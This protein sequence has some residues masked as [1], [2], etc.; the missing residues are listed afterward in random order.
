MGD[1]SVL[2]FWANVIWMSLSGV[3]LLGA[4]IWTVFI[5]WPYLKE[6]KQMQIESLKL[7]KESN[8]ALQKMQGEFIPV[9][10][11]LEESIV[12]IR[13][14]VH[15]VKAGEGRVGDAIKKAVKDGRKTFKD[16]E[17]ELET[18]VFKKVDGFLGDVFG[19]SEEGEPSDDED[20]EKKY[21]SIID[22][23]RDKVVRR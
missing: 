12:N 16:G 3:T 6:T 15:D 23:V 19:E 1:A 14:V 2:P 10:K 5:F 8:D 9:L 22:E 21:D 18:W 20:G 13:D 17:S 4:C 7:G 11:D